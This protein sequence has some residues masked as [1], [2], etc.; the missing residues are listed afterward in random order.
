MGRLKRR[1]PSK[2]LTIGL[3]LK[4][5]AYLNDLVEEEG[6][7]DTPTEVARNLL[8]RAIQDLVKDGVI[9]RRRGTYSEHLNE[10]SEAGD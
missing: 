1:K 10:A 9:D 5:H 8:S 6:Y 2:P 3:T 4:L 7:G